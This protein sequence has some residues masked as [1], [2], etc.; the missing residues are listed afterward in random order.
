MSAFLTV[1][2]VSALAGRTFTGDELNR[3]SALLP[4]VSDALRQ[5]AVKVG[6]NLDAMMAE[7]ESYTSL[8]KLVTADVLIRVLRQSTVGEPVSQTSQSAGGL[9]ISQTYAIPGG[10]IAASI[11]KNDLKR[12][13][14]RRQV[15]RGIE[16][17]VQQRDIL[18]D[19]NTV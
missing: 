6:R 11:M 14:L 3:L 13:G 8:V 2:E 9:S 15:I 16:L 19:D 4:L 17:Y 18:P 5:E 1:E 7:D 12:L 10:G